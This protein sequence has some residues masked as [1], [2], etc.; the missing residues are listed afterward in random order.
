MQLALRS[1]WIPMLTSVVLACGSG[2]DGDPVD[3]GRADDAGD[4]DAGTHGGDRDGGSPDGGSDGGGRADDAGSVDGG[5]TTAD[6]G[7]PAD[8][9]IGWAFV[10]GLTTGGAGGDTVTVSTLAE[11]RAA[12]GSP[13]PMIILVSGTITGTGSVVVRSNKSILGLPGALLDGVGLRLFGTSTS[14]YVSNIIVRDLTIRNVRATD[15]ATGGGDNDCIGLKWAEHVWIDHCDL[16]ADLS[17]PDDWEYYDGL[18][19]ISKQSDYVTVSWTR[20]STSFKGSGVGGSSDAGLGRLRVTYHHN[21]FD[22]IAERAPSFSY[23]TGGHVFSNYYVDGATPSGY[24][25]G[26]R[27]GAVMRVE[28]NFFRRISHPIRTEIDSDPGFVSGAS[29]NVYEDC[30]EPSITTTSTWAPPYA[31]DTAITPAEDVPAVVTSGV[32]PR[33]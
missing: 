15:P 19:D 16:S 9:R 22:R 12:A 18:V 8:E 27:F 10:D 3:A 31:Y 6:S 11:L 24:A 1:I 7:A 33:S 32:G 30:G 4:G 14:D 25:V 21:L 17:H 20:F 29:T 28:H 23:G 13:S 5:G 26:S 2:P